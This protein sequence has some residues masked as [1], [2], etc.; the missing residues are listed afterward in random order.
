MAEVWLVF[1]SDVEGNFLLAVCATE[2]TAKQV[3]LDTKN[4]P[5]EDIYIEA[6]DIKGNLVGD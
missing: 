2:W 4:I 6:W 3:K 5:Q 1:H